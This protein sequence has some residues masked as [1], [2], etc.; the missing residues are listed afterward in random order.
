MA[1]ARSRP[2]VHIGIIKRIKS[3]EKPSRVMPISCASIAIIERLARYIVNSSANSDQNSR[4]I[5]YGVIIFPYSFC[6][7]WS[8]L[9]RYAT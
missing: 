8:T 5:H 9:A 6:R 7:G 4:L 2:R 3:P 1:D